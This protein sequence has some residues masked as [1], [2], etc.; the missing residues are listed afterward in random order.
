M[1]NNGPSTNPYGT[2]LMQL[3]EANCEMLITAVCTLSFNPYT[4][5]QLIELIVP[6]LKPTFGTTAVMQMGGAWHQ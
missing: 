1:N 2:S 3:D 5:I 4:L 6:I